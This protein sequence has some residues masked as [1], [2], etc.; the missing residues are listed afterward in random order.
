MVGKFN[1]MENTKNSEEAYGIE[2]HM[3][4]TQR[5][6]NSRWGD[7]VVNDLKMLKLK[8][9]TYIVKDRNGFVQKTKNPQGVVLSAAEEEK[10]ELIEKDRNTGL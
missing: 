10:E 1:M 5:A 3:N 4:E 9:W 2:C 8:K 6:Y 7:E